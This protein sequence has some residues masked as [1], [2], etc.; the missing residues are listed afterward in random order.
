M[1]RLRAVQQTQPG[2]VKANDAASRRLGQ[3]MP[4]PAHDAMRVPRRP[5]EA[6]PSSARGVGGDIT[7][8][9][10]CD[11]RTGVARRAVTPKR[12]AAGAVPH[13]TVVELAEAGNREAEPPA[14]AGIIGGQTMSSIL[15]PRSG[16]LT[17]GRRST[18]TA[19][20]EGASSDPTIAATWSRR[21]VI[22]PWSGRRSAAARSVAGQ[23]VPRA[24]ISRRSVMRAAPLCRIQAVASGRGIGRAMP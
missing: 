10:R 5:P 19:R 1:S 24:R 13:P 18:A 4:T 17:G 23:A 3:A 2:E 14:A 7:A 12:I 16:G 9:R 11:A 6:R 21:Q 20:Q 22:R 8:Q 15:Q